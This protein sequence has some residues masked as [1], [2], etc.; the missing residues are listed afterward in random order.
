M[1]GGGGLGMMHQL[2][3]LYI[4]LCDHRT[5]I[6][7]GVNIVAHNKKGGCMCFFCGI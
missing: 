2:G 5:M 4:I 1:G 3:C 7:I 6:G